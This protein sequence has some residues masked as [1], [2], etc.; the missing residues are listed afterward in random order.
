MIFLKKREFLSNNYEQ[1]Y[2]ISPEVS[3]KVL[4]HDTG[5]YG[6]LRVDVYPAGYS[7]D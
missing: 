7:R 3:R 1:M 5:M 6:Y 2:R 4:H